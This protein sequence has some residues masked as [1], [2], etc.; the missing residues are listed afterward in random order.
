[1]PALRIPLPDWQVHI[2]G[3]V[4]AALRAELATPGLVFHGHVPDL[5]PWM[6]TCLASIAP[7]RFGA[8]V[9]GKINMAMSYGLPV[10]ATTLAVEGM[11]LEDGAN[12]M[13]ADTAADFAH[14]ARTLYADGPLWNGL[15]AA[16]IDNVKR[17]F[18]AH[19]ASTILEKVLG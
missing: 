11:Y 13:L 16:A 18:S 19:L 8:G 12:V 6:D 5:A 17:H 14:A 15:S 2:V 4:P 7:L 3:S 10:I 1:V 9:K